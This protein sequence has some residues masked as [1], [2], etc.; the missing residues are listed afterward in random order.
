MDKEMFAVGVFVAVV[1]IAIAAFINVSSGIVLAA[2]GGW[3]AGTA[4]A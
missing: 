3:V 2:I 1:G 4:L